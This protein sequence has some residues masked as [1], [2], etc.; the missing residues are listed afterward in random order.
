M[1]FAYVFKF[2]AKTPLLV[3]SI[4]SSSDFHR[5]RFSAQ[6]QALETIWGTSR[7][8]LQN[9]GSTNIFLRRNF[10]SFM[11][12]PNRSRIQKMLLS[13]GESYCLKILL[14]KL[15]WT[16]TV[17]FQYVKIKALPNDCFFL[18]ISISWSLALLKMLNTQVQRIISALKKSVGNCY[19]E[20]LSLRMTKSFYIFSKL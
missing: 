11:S 2:Y 1:K 4:L 5:Q 14:R 7:N 6:V 8:G 17:V 12:F 10:I 15:T 20:K 13:A 19:K 9:L 18:R 16:I 3:F